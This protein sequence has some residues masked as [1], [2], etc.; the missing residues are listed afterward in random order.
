MQRKYTKR[1]N[2]VQVMCDQL[3]HDD[4]GFAGDDPYHPYHAYLDWI[5]LPEAYR[6]DRQL[7]HH[8]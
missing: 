7:N 2:M 5:G 4:A 8:A 1:P 3:R 6:H